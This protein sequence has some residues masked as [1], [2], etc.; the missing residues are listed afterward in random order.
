[1]KVKV[2]AAHNFEIELIRDVIFLD[3]Q[4][5]Q[6]DI[7]ML[8]QNHSHAIYDKKS[9][10]IEVIEVSYEDN[11]CLVKVNGNIYNVQ[12]EDRYNELLKELG[13]DTVQGNKIKDIKAPMPGL[14][15][16]VIVAEGAVVKKGDSLLILEAMKMENILK[17]PAEGTIKR[18]WINKGDKV[19]KNELLIEF[20]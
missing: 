19:E 1:M 13:M 10:N 5:I 3:G 8:S 11:S 7:R 17:S 14:V 16:N 18:I 12:L 2:N 15:L 20:S 4:E 6:P 9:Y